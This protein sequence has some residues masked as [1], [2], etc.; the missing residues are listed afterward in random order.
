MID[1]DNPDHANTPASFHVMA[2]SVFR[3]SFQQWEW[4]IVN[5]GSTGPG[6]WRS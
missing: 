5:D 3:Q 6:P 1:P 4:L 2:W